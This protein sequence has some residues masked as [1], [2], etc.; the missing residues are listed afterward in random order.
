M[1]HLESFIRIEFSILLLSLAAI[2]T[3][4][5]LTGQITLSGLLFDKNG[6]TKSDAGNYSPAR[7]Q[8]LMLTIAGAAYYF[9]LVVINLHAGQVELPA[10]PEKWLLM[11]GGSH[12]IY[13]GGKTYSLFGAQSRTR[14]DKN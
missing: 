13:L 14:R 12:S 2:V 7:V 9:S 6:E 8:L 3:Y 11:L 10:I 1:R 5:L 4:R